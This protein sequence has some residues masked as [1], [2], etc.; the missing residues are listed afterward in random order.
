MEGG[1]EILLGR[2]ADDT[3]ITRAIVGALRE[4][5]LSGYELWR[6]VTA[7]SGSANAASVETA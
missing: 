4:R 7:S 1:T 5:D 2:T 3:R 6:W